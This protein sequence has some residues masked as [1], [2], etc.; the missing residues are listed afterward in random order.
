MVVATRSDPDLPLSYLRAHD[1]LIEITVDELRFNCDE[2]RA[3]IAAVSDIK[4]S[5]SETQALQDATEG[6]AVGLQI[7]AIALR[8]RNCNRNE[9]VSAFSRPSRAISDYLAENVLARIGPETV[10]FMLRTSLLRRLNADLCER[11][12]GMSDGRT[13]LEWLAGQNM[14]L[15]RIDDND[16]WYRY[17]AL[18]AQFLRTQLHRKLDNELPVLHMRAAEWLAEHELWAEAVQHALAAGRID[19]ATD[20]VEC[21]AMHEVEDSRVNNL[22]T[23]ARKLPREAI[24]GR[25]RLRI[26][27][28]WALLLTIR[29]HEVESIITDMEAQLA[30]GELAKSDDLQVE[31]EALRFALMVI[32]D[33]IVNALYVGERCFE[34]LIARDE[35]LE[36]NIWR[37]E[38]IL[39]CLSYCY[40]MSGKIESARSILSD[41][42]RPGLDFANNLFTLSYQASILGSCDLRECCLEDAAKRLREALSLCESRVG[43]SSAAASLLAGTLAPILYEWNQLEELEELL[44]D[45][46]DIIDEAC[47]LGAVKGAYLSLARLCVS[48]NE[49]EAAHGL[50]DRAEIVGHKRSWTR[51]RAA[52]I[53]EHVR[54]WFLQNRP[55]DAARDAR[56]LEILATGVDLE[57]KANAEILAILHVVRA[58]MA[59]HDY[60]FDDAVKILQRLT[61]VQDEN[62]DVYAAVG[63]RVLL[64][65]A[66]HLAGDR[67]AA[68]ATLSEV[69]R[70]GRAA[71]LIR[72]IV[73]EAT[74]AGL[75]TLLSCTE[76]PASDYLAH[77][78]DYLAHLN[79]KN[80]S[81]GECQP[82]R[83]GASAESAQA[84]LE[85][86]SEREQNVLDLVAKGLSNKHIARALQ[87]SLGTV[88]WHLKNVYGKLGVSSRTMAVHKAR[89]IG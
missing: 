30:S 51:L 71:R 58:R 53:A 76:L 48:Q 52:C 89:K 56:R 61:A 31:L 54:I 46:L 27:I 83:D 60:R 17:H 22:L 55:L 81:V 44:A 5:A 67:P 62:I 34:Y 77:L 24:R 57:R 6:W 43:R 64:A 25:P 36:G 42:R 4:L 8:R 2:T 69:L 75:E 16:E 86:L 3:F 88:K 23:W 20:W 29:D 15:Y 9:V 33:D 87:I 35:L 63:T 65:A 50:L 11:V 18:F 37:R 78:K 66:Y 45:R 41:H 47:Y 70:V 49:L 19:Q 13:I 32:K 73:D 40:A 28:A 80:G 85:A 74:G 12:S 72:C 10:T 39:N 82:C 14:F 1:Q 26:A 68:L 79:Q 59:L 7:A 21:C 38:A 84:M